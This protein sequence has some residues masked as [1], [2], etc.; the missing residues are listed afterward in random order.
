M[1]Y[2]EE[3]LLRE[4][5]ADTEELAGPDDPGFEVWYAGRHDGP[6]GEAHYKHTLDLA[7]VWRD[8]YAAGYAAGLPASRPS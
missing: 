4:Y 8:R 6:E 5:L 2:E 1:T 3:T 7:Q